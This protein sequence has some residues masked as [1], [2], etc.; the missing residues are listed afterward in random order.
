[1]LA[2]EFRNRPFG[3]HG[4]MLPMPS[5]EPPPPPEPSVIP[6]PDWAAEERE[7]KERDAGQPAPPEQPQA[8]AVERMMAAAL[9]LGEIDEPPPLGPPLKIARLERFRP[10]EADWDA[11][12]REATRRNKQA[13][14]DHARQVL[15]E[16]E[17]PSR[18]PPPQRGAA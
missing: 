15:N 9:E 4:E 13:Q 2:D 16:E 17:T 6:P 8:T 11:E 18:F 10:P 1:M 3:T 5:V 12:E 7:R 14:R